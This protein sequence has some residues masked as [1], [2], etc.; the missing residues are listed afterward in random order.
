MFNGFLELNESKSDIALFVCQS[1]ITLIVCV[2]VFPVCCWKPVLDLSW[3]GQVKETVQFCF[4]HSRNI[5]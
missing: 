4:V 1:T 5:I 3:V 2:Y